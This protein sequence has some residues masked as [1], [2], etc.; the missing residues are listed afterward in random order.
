MSVLG[1]GLAALMLF[2]IGAIE[3]LGWIFLLFP[4][5]VLLISVYILID[6]YRKKVDTAASGT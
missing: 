6:N 2:R 1:Y 4:L 3:R 5:W